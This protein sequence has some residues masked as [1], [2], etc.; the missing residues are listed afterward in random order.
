MTGDGSYLGSDMLRHYSLVSAKLRAESTPVKLEPG[1]PTYKPNASG[2]LRG[3]LLDRLD[4]QPLIVIQ[5]IRPSDMPDREVWA[6]PVCCTMLVNGDVTVW[7]VPD[8]D[9]EMF[10]QWEEILTAP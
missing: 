7:P 9:Y 2:R 4:G 5:I 10:L 1:K 3:V 8:R 6:T